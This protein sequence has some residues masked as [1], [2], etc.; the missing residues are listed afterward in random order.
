LFP[1]KS[2]ISSIKGHAKLAKIEVFVGLLSL[3]LELVGAVCLTEL[4]CVTA[5]DH[6]F[7]TEVCEQDDANGVRRVVDEFHYGFPF[8]VRGFIIALVE[9]AKN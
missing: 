7:D 5:L 2:G 3:N 8:K 6:P 1:F 9:P 4:N